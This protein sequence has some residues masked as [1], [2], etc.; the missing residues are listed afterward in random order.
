MIPK[1]RT[2]QIRQLQFFGD[3]H[4]FPGVTAG[5]RRSKSRDVSEKSKCSRDS[6]RRRVKNCRTVEAPSGQGTQNGRIAEARGAASRFGAHPR[7]DSSMD[8]LAE[9]PGSW[10]N[11]ETVGVLHSFS[12]S[13]LSVQWVLCTVPA[14][15]H[16]AAAAAARLPSIENT[17][18][19][20]PKVES[21]RWKRS[22]P[23]YS[24]IKPDPDEGSAESAAGEAQAGSMDL[25]FG[26][27][28]G[29]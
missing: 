18:S 1:S 4:T 16:C 14:G 10:D 21:Q 13:S 24:I 15:Q 19:P 11:G 12:F 25:H 3:I 6:S 22:N 8:L 5:H 9:T 20:T 2:R 17:S 29:P 7:S 27:G 28:T 23:T 26:G